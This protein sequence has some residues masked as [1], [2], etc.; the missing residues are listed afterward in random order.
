VDREATT[1]K[2]PTLIFFGLLLTPANTYRTPLNLHVRYA[3]PVSIVSRPEGLV[4]PLPMT[5]HFVCSLTLVNIVITVLPCTLPAAFVRAPLK[6]LYFFLAV[7]PSIDVEHRV[8]I[9]GVAL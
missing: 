8:V 1:R 2:T 3:S 9:I 7:S 5:I 6:L 4:L